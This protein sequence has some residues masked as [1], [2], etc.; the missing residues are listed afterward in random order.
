MD[1][2]PELTRVMAL[3]KSTLAHD[4][5]AR[6]QHRGVFCAAG[7][8]RT[9]KSAVRVAHRG[10][11]ALDL[12]QNMRGRYYRANP[13][14]ARHVSRKEG[15]MLSWDYLCWVRAHPAKD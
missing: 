9:G 1:S 4:K 7:V 11:G 2:R 14:R 13:A 10:Y 15:D 6:D 5:R 8:C 12:R 3:R